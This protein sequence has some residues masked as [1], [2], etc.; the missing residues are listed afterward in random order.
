MRMISSHGC[1]SKGEI[2]EIL[3]NLQCEYRDVKEPLEQGYGF[4]MED[5][6]YRTLKV[7]NPWNNEN[8]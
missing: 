8:T 1:S 6:L 4:G 3:S 7:V 2:I 5:F